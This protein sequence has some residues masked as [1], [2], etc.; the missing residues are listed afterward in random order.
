MEHLSLEALHKKCRQRRNN[1]CIQLY[2]S[3]QKILWIN[4]SLQGT[5]EL[6]QC[7]G[8]IFQKSIREKSVSEP[9]KNF[10][11]TKVVC[12]DSFCSLTGWFYWSIILPQNS[13]CRIV[14]L[15]FWDPCHKKH[16]FEHCTWD[17]PAVKVKYFRQPYKIWSK[18]CSHAYLG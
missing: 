4:A 18:Y 14:K 10:C 16:L 6:M 12:E 2:L 3:L 9:C 11:N 13:E 8:H 5:C 15:R 7:Q 1:Q 17:I